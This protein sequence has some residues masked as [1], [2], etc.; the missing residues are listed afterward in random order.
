VL[1]AT[2][3]AGSAA[4]SVPARGGAG[5]REAEFCL[6]VRHV[7]LNPVEHGPVSTPEDRAWPS[8]RWRMERREGNVPRDPPTGGPRPW[9]AWKAAGRR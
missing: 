2:E 4:I 1:R 6:E 7:H 8:V 9:A 5:R 3:I